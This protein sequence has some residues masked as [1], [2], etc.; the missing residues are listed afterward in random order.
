MVIFLANMEVNYEIYQLV[1]Y[2]IPA[3]ISST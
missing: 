3:G 1:Y 2:E